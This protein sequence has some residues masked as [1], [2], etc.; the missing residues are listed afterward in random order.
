MTKEEALIYIDKIK[1]DLLKNVS[2]QLKGLPNSSELCDHL[3]A[4]IKRSF[5]QTPVFDSDYFSIRCERNMDTIIIYANNLYSLLWLYGE[6]VTYEEVRNKT[7][8]ITDYGTY[9]FEN[10]QSYFQDNK[11]V[12]YITVNFTLPIEE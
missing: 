6:T 10:G 8:W 3:V 5:S 9:K 12:E 2:E 4:N 11:P 7:Y 1:D